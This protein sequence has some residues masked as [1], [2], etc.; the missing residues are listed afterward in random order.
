MFENNFYFLIKYKREALKY[1]RGIFLITRMH[2]FPN[3]IQSVN[4]TF[5]LMDGFSVYFLCFMMVQNNYIY[6]IVVFG[7]GKKQN[8]PLQKNCNYIPIYSVYKL[9]TEFNNIIISIILL[10][11]LY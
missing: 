9:S 10:I 6:I 3:L 8:S 4:N 11:L 2:L 5:F 7:D 1:L